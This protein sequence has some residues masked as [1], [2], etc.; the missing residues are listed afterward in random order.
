MKQLR[1]ILLAVLA[2]AFCAV[3]ASA[4]VVIFSDLG[5]GTN[6]YNC[7]TGWT[8]S[9]TGTLGT[10]FINADLFTVSGSGDEA[11]EQIDLAVANAEG[12]STFDASIWTVDNGLPGSQ[13]AGAS[14]TGLIATPGFGGCCTL[15][16]ITGITGVALTGGQDYFMVLGPVST[17][18]NS[19][20]AWNLNTVGLSTLDL[21]S[22]DGGAT[23][24]SN[25]SPA[26]G[27]FDILGSAVVM[28][29]PGSL[30]L[31][32]AG[33]AGIL[34]FRRRSSR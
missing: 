5:S 10:S 22:N 27:A 12:A 1:L 7:C 14:W 13:V 29:E 6:V 34:A 8:V 3:P 11:V 15:I 30:L 19:W 31:L 2:F 16:S 28:P 17:S 21:Y 24:I 32:G 9:G 18:D 25:G 23:W 4:S 33:L 20:N 26:T